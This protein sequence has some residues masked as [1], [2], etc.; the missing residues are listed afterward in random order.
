MDL[1]LRRA[2]GPGRGILDRGRRPRGLGLAR[3][4]PSR[5]AVRLWR[6]WP[7]V[8]LRVRRPVLPVT[9]RQ[10]HQSTFAGDGPGRRRKPSAE[11]GRAPRRLRDRRGLGIQPA[12]RRREPQ[13]LRGDV[14]KAARDLPAPRDSRP[15]R[16]APAAR[17]MVP[18]STFFDKTRTWS[19]P[20]T[21]PGTGDFEREAGG[22]GQGDP[23]RPGGVEPLGLRAD[24]PGERGPHEARRLRPCPPWRRSVSARPSGSPTPSTCS[25]CRSTSLS[26]SRPPRGQAAQGLTPAI[27]TPRG[28]WP[29]RFQVSAD[30]VQ[31]ERPSRPGRS[32]R[33]PGSRRSRRPWRSRARRRR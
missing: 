2:C 27:S 12:V 30:E 9:F 20:R 4:G 33:W 22:G 25:C 19:G 11:S 32:G 7:G 21:R 1:K 8:R 28:P 31:V 10:L 24:H 17:P 18:L 3:A 13:G 14:A 16:P 15:S 29:R 6:L 23:G 26:A 5:G